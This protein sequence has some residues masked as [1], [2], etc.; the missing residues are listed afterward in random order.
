MPWVESTICNVI[1]SKAAIQYAKKYG[2][3]GKRLDYDPH[4][5]VKQS[6]YGTPTLQ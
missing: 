6:I 1:T 2:Q 5:Q 4:K 3:A